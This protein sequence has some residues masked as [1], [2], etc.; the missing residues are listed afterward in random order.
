MEILSYQWIVPDILTSEGKI[1]IVQDNVDI[2]YED[3]ND[4]FTISS[5]SINYEPVLVKE[6][7]L[8]SNTWIGTELG[9]HFHSYYIK[10]EGDITIN[11][12]VYKKI[13]K[14]EDESQLNWKLHGYIREDSSNFNTC[15][16]QGFPEG[17]DDKADESNSICFLHLKTIPLFH[18][19]SIPL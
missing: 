3:I 8:W 5:V 15:F 4:N 17:I 6:N 11:N 10:F 9:D 7:K 19:K 12:K 2:D 1:R 14:S 13:F 16:P 18:F